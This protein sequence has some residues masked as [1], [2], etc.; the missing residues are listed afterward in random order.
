MTVRVVWDDEATKQ[1][2]HYIY[3]GIWTWDEHYQTIKDGLLLFDTVPHTV[4]LIIDM[5]RSPKFPPGNVFS[6]L[7]AIGNSYHARAGHTIILNDNSFL[8]TMFATFNKVYK[9]KKVTG[10]V[11]F[12]PDIEVARQILVEL[13]QTRSDVE[14]KNA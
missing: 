3:E 2:L 13:R 8:R 7:R 11:F 5:S 14:N 9:P 4:D 6:H 1:T 12:A 10:K